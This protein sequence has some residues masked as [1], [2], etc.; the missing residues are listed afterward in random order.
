MDNNKDLIN[1]ANAL[2]KATVAC[3]E[4]GQMTKDLALLIHGKDMKR[5]DY[6][7]TIDFID[8]VKVM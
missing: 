3:V 8:A 2:E 7:S 1:Y 4:S 5:S 6:L